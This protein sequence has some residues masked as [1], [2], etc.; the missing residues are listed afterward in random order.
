MTMHITTSIVEM[1]QLLWINFIVKLRNLIEYF[2][3][4]FRYYG[5][6]NFRRI[7]LAFLRTYLFTNP[8][9]ISK[10]FLLLKG[11]KELYA[12]GETPLTTLGEIATDC[13]ITPQDSVYELGCGRGRACFWLNTYLGCQVVGIDYVPDFIEKAEQL[14]RKYDLKNIE[15]RTQDIL[16]ADYTGATLLYLYGTCYEEPFIKKLISHLK[17]L[18]KGTRIIS[19]SYP[20]TDYAPEDQFRLIKQ[21]EGSFNWGEADIYLQEIL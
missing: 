11:E 14:V 5:N 2:R 16:T 13:N 18:P 19:V 9:K 3:V 4:I 12:Y 1:I 10:K 6:A 21:F 7:D 15:F 17:G 8:F 20:L